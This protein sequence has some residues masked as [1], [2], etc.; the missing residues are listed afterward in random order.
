MY[1]ARNPLNLPPIFWKNECKPKESVTGK[2]S[3]PFLSKNKKEKRFQVRN[4]KVKKQVQNSKQRQ[5]KRYLDNHYK[6]KQKGKT[7]ENKTRKKSNR[8]LSTRKR[9][10]WKRVKKVELT[11]LQ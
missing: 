9:K 7:K 4:Q 11:S 2:S 5:K 8:N 6:L 3:V 10:D 1:R